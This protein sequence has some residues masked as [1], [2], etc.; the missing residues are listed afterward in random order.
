MLVLELFLQTYP[1][2]EKPVQQESMC[3]KRVVVEMNV[4]E[5][6]E[7]VGRLSAIEKVSLFVFKIDHLC[8]GNCCC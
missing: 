5:A 2:V 7:F 4:D 8:S 6:R 1:E 3:I